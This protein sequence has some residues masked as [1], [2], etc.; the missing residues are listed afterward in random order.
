VDGNVK[1]PFVWNPEDRRQR[2]ARLD[3]LLMHLYGLKSPTFKGL[4]AKL[5]CCAKLLSC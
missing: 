4:T 1:P 3:A 2:L 5:A